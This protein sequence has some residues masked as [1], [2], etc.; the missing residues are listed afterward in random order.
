MEFSIGGIFGLY[1][2]MIFG[3]LGWW[4]GRKKAKKNRGLDEVH[5]HIWQKAKSYSWYMTLAAIYIFFSL[6][7]FGIK[8][9]TAMV[10]A[11]LLFVHLGSWAIIG[12]ILTINMYSP[13]PFKPSYVKLGISINVA[14]ILIF[15]II[16]IITNNWL[17][18]LFSILP[19]MMGIFTALTVNRKDFK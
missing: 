2:G 16:S 3:I 15:T 14:S 17:F 10:L 1:G 12:L 11:V 18:L 7:V 5:D 4:F 9:S 19:S 13:I 8:L 6:I